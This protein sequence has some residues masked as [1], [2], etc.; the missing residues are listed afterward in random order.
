MSGNFNKFIYLLGA[1]AAALSV[2]PAVAQEAQP[3][4]ETQLGDVVVTAQRREEK[5]QN[6]PIAVTALSNK[7]MEEKQ[8]TDVLSLGKVAPGLQAKPS[9]NP[10]EITVAIR[11]ITQLLPSINSDPA[12]GTYVDGIYNVLN[13]GGNNG[14]IDMERAEVLR[15][16]QG[17]LFGRNT[18]GG[19]ISITTNKP[20]NEFEGYVQGDIGNYGAWTGTGVVNVPI[21]ADK[22]NT[23]FVYQHN[24]RD[25]YGTNF[26]TGNKTNELNSDY[27]RASAQFNF[28]ADWDLLVSANYAKADGTSPPSRL[29]YIN[30]VTGI[31]ATLPGIGTIP[32]SINDGVPI[33]SGFAEYYSGGPGDLLTNYIGQNA[34][35]GDLQDA[36]MSIDNSF[37]LK[38]TNLMATLTG[39]LTDD[40]TFKS[41]SGYNKTEYNSVEDV[42]ATPYKVLDAVGYPIDAKQWSEELQLLGNAL[43]GK[44]TWITGLYYYHNEGS[45]IFKAV[46]F[47]WFSGPP[48]SELIN[49]QGPFADNTSYSAFAQGTYALTPELNLTAGVRYVKDERRADYHDNTALASTGAYLRC[50]LANA[51]GDLN[52]ANCFYS[53]SVDYDYA[54]WTIGLDYKANENLMV[55]GKVSKGFRSGAFTFAGPAAVYQADQVTPDA[56]GNAFA[57]ANFGPVAPEE[58]LSQEAGIKGDFLDKRLRVNAAIYHMEYSNI[59]LARNLNPP[60]GCATCTPTSVLTNSGKAEFNG[61]ELEATALLGDLTVDVAAGYVDPEYTEGPFLGQPLINT[62]DFNGSINLSYPIQF[63][64]GKLLLGAGYSYRSK[65]VLYSVLGVPQATRDA[66]AQ[67]GYGLLDARASFAFDNAPVTISVYGTN[68]TDEEYIVSAFDFGSALGDLAGQIPGSPLLFGGSVKYSF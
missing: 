66:V 46:A 44:L 8:I 13:A 68:L 11:G 9:F 6:V 33:L 25:G 30:P 5:L 28:N 38:S 42:D 15:G 31:T 52:P 61:V 23:R 19:T 27:F 50:N 12:I 55:Y 1:C 41:I 18:I 60:A 58:V 16:P 14:M 51:P 37:D 63:S 24:E 21:V 48:G 65:T 29:A 40:L 45:Q 57:L 39:Q 20:T 17:T 35:T 64:A 2:T 3:S 22:I 36:N 59:Q 32:V 54:P 67:D 53:A 7:A 34:L 26:F 56:V 43:D 10:M 49:P 47:P 4:S 62:S